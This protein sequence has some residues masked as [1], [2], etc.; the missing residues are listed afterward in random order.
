M[1]CWGTGSAGSVRSSRLP[2]SYGRSM[3]ADF[4]TG[5]NG[6]SSKKDRTSQRRTAQLA[7]A[8]DAEDPPSP[9]NVVRRN[10]DYP[11]IIP[12]QF[13]YFLSTVQSQKVQVVRPFISS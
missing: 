9:G 5:R 10:Q 13:T 7:S 4:V 12:G 8:G 2:A 1:R 6:N 3:S 11:G